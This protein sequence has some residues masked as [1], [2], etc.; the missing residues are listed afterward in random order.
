MPDLLEKCIK[1]FKDDRINSQDERYL[2][3]WV[4]YASMSQKPLDLYTF[5]HSNNL[6][7]KLPEFYVHWAWALEQIGNYKK[8]EQA[9]KAGVEMV[10]RGDPKFESMEVKHR[11]FQ[12]RVM[13]RMVEQNCEQNE[14]TEGIT[15]EEERSVLGSLQG[16]GK[17]QK[18]GSIRIGSAKKSDQPGALPLPTPVGPPQRAGRGFVIFQDGENADPNQAS[19]KSP[20]K[21]TK[22]NSLPFTK[23]QNRENELNAGKWTKSNIGKKTHAVPLDKIDTTPRFSV[24]QDEGLQQPTGPTPH[25][26]QP[27]ESSVLLAKKVTND[28]D[29]K[30]IAVALFEPPDPSKRAMYCKHLVYQ[31]TTE[32]SFEEIRAAKWRKRREAEQ[33]Q[34]KQEEMNKMMKQMEEE[35]EAMRRDKEELREQQE[36]LRSMQEDALRQQ[37]EAAQEAIKQQRE[38][39]ARQQEE[40]KKQMAQMLQMKNSNAS[41]TSSNTNS[42]IQQTPSSGGLSSELAS[43]SQDTS[44]YQYQ[45][46][47]SLLE[48]TKTLLQANPLVRIQIEIMAGSEIE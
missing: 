37:Q 3:V 16:H 33:L 19:I 42:N 35:R 17:H 46:S 6:C 1:E 2:E 38:E 12:A 39:M 24:H 48:D 34:Q 40:F 26:L 4:K 9:F 31:G 13:K 32:F 10:D 44:S 29:D 25:K 11:Q 23:E 14:A 47:S 30:N 43:N 27:G 22:S 41:S 21:N 18:V 28:E 5:M 36:R 45:R 15:A 7:T 20:E 8:A